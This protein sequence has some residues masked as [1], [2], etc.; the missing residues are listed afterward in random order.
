MT[1]VEYIKEKRP[2]LAV[3]S[4]KTYGSVLKSLYEKVFGK[5]DIDY[6]KYDDTEKILHF[7]KDVPFNKRKSILSALVIITDNKK[8]RELM[9]NDIKDYNS[10]IYKQEKTEQQKENWVD[11]GEIK[12]IWEDLKKN[13]DLLY[14]KKD[15]KANDLQEIQQFI[16]LSLLGGI[17]IPPRR[18]LDFC[19]F[20]IASPDKQTENYLEK[21]K[22]YFNSYKTAKTYGCQDIEIPKELLS[23]LK[24]WLKINPTKYL[25]F[26]NN[27]NQLSSVKLNQRFN[28]I[29]NGK[30]VSVNNMRHTFLTDKFGD[31]IKKNNEISNVMTEM[32][33]SKNMLTTYVKKDD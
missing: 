20:I 21:N 19:N 24:K 16:I 4:L 23:I 9:L 32:G 25:L 28:K 27:N 18:S 2:N 8:Y 13:A 31:T 7:L 6:K 26:D 29:F 30:K 15:L 3:S 5:E 11:M 10:E 33:S 12:N 22:M 14:K 17:F 1:L